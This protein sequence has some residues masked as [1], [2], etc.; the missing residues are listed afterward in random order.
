M[1][2]KLIVALDVKDFI[3]AEKIIEELSPMVDIFKVGS[4]LYTLA[5]NKIIDY[6]HS[7]DKKVFL[8][9]KFYD[10]PN[11]VK[12]ICSVAAELG[13]EMLTIHLLGGREMIKASLEGVK[14]VIIKKKPGYK[15]PLILGVTVLTS[16]NDGIL[17][18]DLK[19]NLSAGELVKHL[20]G[21]GYNEG[22]RGFVCS[23]YEIE[24][25]RKEFG[26]DITLV[27]PGV[28]MPGESNGDQKRVMDPKTAKKLGA[29][30]I[31]MGRSVLEAESKIKS[32]ETILNELI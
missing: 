1:Q 7:K 10:I 6:L 26:N 2:T 18:N 30:Y 32:V 13:I 31:V 24:I 4:I 9:L 28:R 21:L 5:G 17:K 16:M 15:E 8:D 23:P 11:T 25:L 29:D 19:I 14:E 27:T 12:G 22:I 20:A 3:E